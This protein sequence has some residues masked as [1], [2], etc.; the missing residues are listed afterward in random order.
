MSEIDK[1][2]DPENT[3]PLY[4]YNQEGEEV[5]FEQIAVIPYE[6]ET[7]CIL[8]PIEGMEDVPEDAGLVFLITTDSEGE[9]ILDIVDDD[10]KVDAIFDEYEKLL[11]ED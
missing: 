9:E 6:G 7:Y 3:E 10:D 5:A 1:L 11:E 2:F 8:Q 4:L